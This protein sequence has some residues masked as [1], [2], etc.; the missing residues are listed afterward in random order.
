MDYFNSNYDSDSDLESIKSFLIGDDEEAE[1]ASMSTIPFGIEELQSVP[2]Y[3]RPLVQLLAVLG[4]GLPTF[5]L[6]SAAFKGGSQPTIAGQAPAEIDL[7]KAKLISA[8]NEER[9]KTRSLELQNALFQQSIDVTVT[10]SKA[11]TKPAPIAKPTP[12]QKIA[13]PPAPKPVARTNPQPVYQRPAAPI[14]TQVRTAPAVKPQ[15]ITKQ[16]PK[17][18]P[19]QQWLA[20][21]NRGHYTTAHVTDKKQS[22]RLVSTKVPV[23]ALQSNSDN[24]S[25]LNDSQVKTALGNTPLMSDRE[26]IA[27]INGEN[28]PPKKIDFQKPK[29]AFAAKSTNIIDIGSTAQA[30]LESAVVWSTGTRSQSN[31]KYLLRLKEEFKN[32]DGKVVLPEDT[33]LIATVR[34]YDNSGLL[35]ME[36]AQILHQGQKIDVTP[37]SLLIEGKK[38]SPLKADLKQK[39]D[40]DFWANVGSVVAPGVERALDSASDTLIVQNGSVYRTNSGRDPLTSGAAGIADGVSQT[41]NRRLQ[42]N[43]RESIVSYFQLDSGKTVYLKAYE[44]ISF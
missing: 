22:T 27:R 7:E 40:S 20:L 16:T 33:R 43:Q 4:V 44:D 6:V 24:H 37:G 2:Y 35:A 11:E 26:L 25:L 17:P 9:E 38:G 23:I 30:T 31:K 8:L 29:L 28:R 14:R 3:K 39:G 34:E 15:L 32:I 13:K 42:N 18:D 21:A 19:M 36:V 1:R 41:L 12:T 5:L 10:K